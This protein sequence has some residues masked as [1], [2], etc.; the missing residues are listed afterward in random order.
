MSADF[1]TSREFEGQPL[2][3]YKVL[4]PRFALWAAADLT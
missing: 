2:D 3:Y 4:P 1:Y